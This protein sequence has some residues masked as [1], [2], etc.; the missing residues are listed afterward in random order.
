M[1]LAEGNNKRTQPRIEP[2]SPDPESDA[3]TTRPLRSRRS[4][5]INDGKGSDPILCHKC[6]VYLKDFPW[7]IKRNCQSYG[8]K[9]LKL[10]HEIFGSDTISPAIFSFKEEHDIPVLVHLK[11]RN[12]RFSNLL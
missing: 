1:S 4:N 7:Y 11:I 3:L 8:M 10:W 12:C 6:S 2:G 9:Y 5:K